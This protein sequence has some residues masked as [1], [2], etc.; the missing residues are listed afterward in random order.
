M[1]KC[2]KCGREAYGPIEHG[3]AKALRTPEFYCHV[4]HGR[5]YFHVLEWNK[6]APVDLRI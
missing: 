1:C 5:A 6:H 3:T 2:P 4:Y